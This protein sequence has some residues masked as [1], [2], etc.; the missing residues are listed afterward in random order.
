MSTQGSDDYDK[1][2]PVEREIRD[3]ADRQR[4]ADEQAGMSFISGPSYPP[5]LS[6]KPSL[7]PGN[8]L[9]KMSISWF[10]FLKEHAHAIL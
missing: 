10:L 7:I 9:W 2:S 3:K 8:N 1:L 5:N 6:P 4:E